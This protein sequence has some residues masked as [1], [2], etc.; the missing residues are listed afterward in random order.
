MHCCER[1]HVAFHH[2]LCLWH[3]QTHI[4]CSLYK[5]SLPADMTDIISLV[6]GGCCTVKS[7]NLLHQRQL[8]LPVQRLSEAA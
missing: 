4:L 5:Q 1:L 7:A 8:S 6:I 3:T 2:P